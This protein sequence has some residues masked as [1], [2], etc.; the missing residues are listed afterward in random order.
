MVR[1][2]VWEKLHATCHLGL[3]TDHYTGPNNGQLHTR[4]IEGPA[5]K[6]IGRKSVS[7]SEM[8][9]TGNMAAFL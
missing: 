1:Q 5:N 3:Q 9:T 8:E 4:L 6:D 2:Y 7:E